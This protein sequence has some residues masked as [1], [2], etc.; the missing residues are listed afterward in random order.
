MSAIHLFCGEAEGN[1]RVREGVEVQ[2]VEERA[3]IFHGGRR[4]ALDGS[5]DS[6]HLSLDLSESLF[7]LRGSESNSGD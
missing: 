2:E 4:G 7:V 6:C 1:D 5:S 3:D